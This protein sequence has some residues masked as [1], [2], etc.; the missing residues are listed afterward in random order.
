VG[1]G[2]A[3]PGSA[4]AP[5]R[6]RLYRH[7]QPH[8]ALARASLAVGRRRPADQLRYAASA[9]RPRHRARERARR[10]LGQRPARPLPAQRGGRRAAFHGRAADADRRASVPRRAHGRAHQPHRGT[11]GHPRCAGA[12]NARWPASSPRLGSALHPA[13]FD[14]PGAPR[15]GGAG[16][17]CAGMG[18]GPPRRPR[19]DGGAPSPPGWGSGNRRRKR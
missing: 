12:P 7:P 3:C 19:L 17:G 4:A 11:R 10:R 2:D 5:V 16:A 15:R 14:H 6:A 1:A 13:R 9:D 18:L 8:R